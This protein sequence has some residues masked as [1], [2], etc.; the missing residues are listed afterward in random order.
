MNL[1]TKILVDAAQ[2]VPHMPLDVHDL[3]IDFLAR[4]DI[5]FRA[6]WF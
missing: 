1:N 4:N 5:G 2:S 3:G 6:R